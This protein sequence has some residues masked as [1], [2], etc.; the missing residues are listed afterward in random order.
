MQNPNFKVTKQHH[1]EE[2]TSRVTPIVNVNII[3]T[4]EDKYLLGHW[5]NKTYF[6]KMP[7][8]VKKVIKSNEMWLFPGGRMK[9]TETPQ[10]TAKRILKTELPGVKAQL[11]K[12][13][14]VIPDKGWDPRAYGITIYYLFQYQS[15]QPKPN[16]N[17]DKFQWISRENFIKSK[18]IYNLEK[19]IAREIDVAI[20]SMNVSTDEILVEVD[21]NDKEIGEI[22]KRDAHN[23]SSRYH[24]AAH[25]MVFT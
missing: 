8:S 6:S 5:N 14:T 12:L 10:D 18:K 19:K 9:Y 20:R 21:K 4:N 2:L 13:I 11:K 17:M 23:D 7:K 25:I 16:K 24:R 22:T 15:G 3:V 1:L